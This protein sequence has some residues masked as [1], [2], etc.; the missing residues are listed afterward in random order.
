LTW[1]WPKYWQKIG[2]NGQSFDKKWQKNFPNFDKRKQKLPR[3]WPKI[4]TKV[5]KSA[6]ILTKVVQKDQNFDKMVNIF[7]HSENFPRFFLEISNL[8]HFGRPPK[9]LGGVEKIPIFAYFFAK[10]EK[11]AE[12]KIFKFLSSCQTFDGVKNMIFAK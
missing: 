8:V 5:D 9:I 2:Q 6:S 12:R 7:F 1:F 11:L 10:L 3:E 4:A